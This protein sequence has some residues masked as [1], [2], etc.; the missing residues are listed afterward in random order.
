MSTLR[1]AV[2][3]LDGRHT[4]DPSRFVEFTCP[5]CARADARFDYGD[6]SVR[7][8]G[9]AWGE[10]S[11]PCAPEAVRSALLGGVQ[12]DPKDVERRYRPDLD[13]MIVA[14]TDREVAS[15]LGRR[16][17]PAIVEERDRLA[18]ASA[19]EEGSS[20][21]LAAV[22]AR[23]SLLGSDD[24]RERVSEPDIVEGVIG[25]KGTLSMINGYRGSMKS[26]ATLGMAAAIG[27]GLSTV[28]GLRVSLHEPVLYAY[29]EGASGL[30]RR[31]QAWEAHHG[32]TMEGVQFF[33]EAIN[34]R[35]PQDVRSLALMAQHVGAGVIVLDSVA[36]TGG[37]REDAEDF[38]AYRAGLEALRDATGAAI[39][40]LHNSGHDKTRARGH[41]TLIDGVDSAITMIPVPVTE[42]GGICVKDE[43]SRDSKA[44]TEM[45]LRFEAAGELNPA[46]GETWSGVVVEQNVH[47]AIRV[48][49]AASDDYTRR[50]LGAI[51]ASPSGEVSPGDLVRVLGVRQEG[52]ELGKVMKTVTASGQVEDNGKGSRAKRYRR[53]VVIPT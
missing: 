36:K 8:L 40:A 13:S 27:G 15:I 46:T 41:T 45:K 28:Y 20:E 7:C 47:E 9:R 12:A 43:K 30:S 38:G 25:P 4:S 18:F 16:A 44:L 6:D 3:R 52:G 29:L 48:A 53:P 34:L 19:G 23:F 35:Q 1:E 10:E 26:L 22:L 32:H 42:G 39:V 49:M 37:G 31:V 21:E 50:V 11:V 24:L 2:D 14:A 5:V 33:H 17:A 51:D